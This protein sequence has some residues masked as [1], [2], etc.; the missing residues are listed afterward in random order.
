MHSFSSPGIILKRRN[1]GEADRIVTIYTQK[2]GKLTVMAKGARKTASKKKG[3]LEA[4]THSTCYF[5]QGKGM[6]L[7]TQTQ[8]ID[9]FPENQ[10]SLVAMTQVLQI[11][12]IVD[13]LTVEES[14]NE[15]VFNSLL[16]S[17]HLISRPGFV[18]AELIG[19]IRTILTVLGFGPP[20]NFNEN[21]LK[22]YIE[23]LSN[24]TLK[25][26]EFLTTASQ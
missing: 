17:L 13:K 6:P 5:I 23:D 20:A 21:D 8:I 10:S 18:K 25:S 1:F 3:G 19:N 26:K 4:G 16:H 7:I 12:E 2:F 9:S 24:T 22:A 14:P 15:A 11:L